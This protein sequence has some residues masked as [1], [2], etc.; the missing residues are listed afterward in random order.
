MPRQQ[1]IPGARPVGY[2]LA[3]A[4]ALVASFAPW[5]DGAPEEG[6]TPRRASAQASEGRPAPAV[7]PGAGD[8]LAVDLDALG[9]RELPASR[10]NLFPATS[11]QPAPAPSA[12]AATP[13]QP[14]RPQPPPLPF[15]YLGRMQDRGVPHVFLSIGDRA[16]VAKV[17]VTLEGAYRVTRIDENAVSF[18]YLPLR[19]TQT[20]QMPRRVDP[21]QERE[22]GAPPPPAPPTP[23]LVETQRNA[24][25]PAEA[26]EAAPVSPG[27]TEPAPTQ[28]QPPAR[29]G[30][31]RDP[32]VPS[33]EPEPAQD[34]SQPARN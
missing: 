16:V 24:G 30:I 17:G 28:A 25:P 13:A 29:D 8:L 23:Q 34:A 19:Q 20:F 14:A 31:A 15:G 1:R 3:L 26:E 11:W 21:M 27:A 5:D 12:S 32:G 22:R 4:V 18:L 10:S 2:A 7:T 6:V 33:P 9:R